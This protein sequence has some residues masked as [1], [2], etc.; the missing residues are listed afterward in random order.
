MTLVL[1]YVDK[2]GEVIE[3]F[4]GVI[5]VSDASAQSLKKSVCSFL[6]DHSLST[7]QIRGQ[8]YDGAITNVLNI[9][10]ASYKRRNLIIFGKV[11]TRRGLNQERGLQRPCDT[12]WGSHYKTLENFIDIFQSIL[13]VLGFAAR[14]YPNYLD[15]LTAETLE[16]TIKGFDFSFKL[17][18]I[19][20]VLMIANHLNSSLQKMD[21]DIVNALELLNTAK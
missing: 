13:Y 4:V 8:G 14:K 16:N 10:R 15:K 3:R 11:H 9:V 5:H 18:L 19:L 17:H 6:S 12:R 2:K 20:K 1:R 7:S 21:Q